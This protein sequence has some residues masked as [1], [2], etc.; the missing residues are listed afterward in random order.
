MIAARDEPSRTTPARPQ[1]GRAAVT[2]LNV[3]GVV[4]LAI[5][6]SFGWI[7]LLIGIA[8]QGGTA[9]AYASG[10]VSLFLPWAIWLGSVVASQWLVSRTQALACIIAA[11]PLVAELALFLHFR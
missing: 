7:L 10:A 3:L 8:D 4:P 11:L 2:T 5:V 9:A 6:S 1:F